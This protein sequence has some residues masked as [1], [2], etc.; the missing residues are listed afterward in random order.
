MKASSGIELLVRLDRT[1]P[2]PL[3]VQLERQLREAAR[4]GRLRPGAPLPSTRALATELGVARG[5]V[6]DAYTQLTAE[7]Y[8][9]PMSIPDLATTYKTALVA[10]R[11]PML[12]AGLVAAADLDDAVAAFDERAHPTTTYTPILVAASG[13]RH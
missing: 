11:E 5:V 12:R 9:R 7:G 10:L 6:S 2:L 3:H 4:T 8:L 13:R 1:A